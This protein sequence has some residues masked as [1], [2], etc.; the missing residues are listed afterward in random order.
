MANASR[1][2]TGSEILKPL[3][4]K[5]EFTEL[6]ERDNRRTWLTIKKEILLDFMKEV[7]KIGFAHCSIISV[8]DWPNQ[9]V[10]ELTYHLWSY[11]YQIA[12]TVKTKIQRGTPRIESVYPVWGKSAGIH[13]RELHELF[14][15]KFTGNP[16]LAPLFLEDW[17]GPPPFRKDF[18]W[19]KYV[20]EEYYDKTRERER[21]YWD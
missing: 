11:Q 20:R 8:T 10:F 9:G 21:P 18:D 4:S 6:E 12:L 16:D 19:R 3:R 1:G 7:K 5:F 2:R 15:V 13:E 17:N 14:G